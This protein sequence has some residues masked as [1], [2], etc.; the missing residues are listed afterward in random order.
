[1]LISRSADRLGASDARLLLGPARTEAG[2]MRR[3]ADADPDDEDLRQQREI[4][5]EVAASAA[6]LPMP[7]ERLR[8]AHDQ[9]A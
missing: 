4:D 6:A 2:A 9:R 8:G 3:G 5:A 7:Y 1:V